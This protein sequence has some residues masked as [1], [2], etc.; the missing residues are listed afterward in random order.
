[1][2]VYH[3]DQQRGK[4]M[5]RC[6]M[7]LAG[8]ILFISGRGEGFAEIRSGKDSQA[9]SNRLEIDLSIKKTGL[10][11]VVLAIGLFFLYKYFTGSW[12]GSV[13]L[14]ILMVILGF[15]FAAVAGYLVGLIGSSNNPISGL[16]LLVR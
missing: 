2:G 12:G 10:G 3:E 6:W 13:V 7:I 14:T 8:V 1:M 16:T 5:A 9:S 4:S 15:L 11:I